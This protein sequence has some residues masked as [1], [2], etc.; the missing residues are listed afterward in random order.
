MSQIRFFE[1]GQF[2]SQFVVPK[3]GHYWILLF[4]ANGLCVQPSLKNLGCTSTINFTFTAVT[5][6]VEALGSDQP[7]LHH[8][9][10]LFLHF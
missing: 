6:S 8:F 4:A 1:P 5:H 10:G 7:D 9:Q 3:L 2:Y